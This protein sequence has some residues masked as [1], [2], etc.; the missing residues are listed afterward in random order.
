MHDVDIL[1]S[2]VARLE[3][4]NRLM[5]HLVAA[6]CVVAVALGTMAQAVPVGEM[7]ATAFVLVDDGGQVIGRLG[8]HGGSPTLELRDGRGA[9]VRLRANEARGTIEYRDGDGRLVDVTRAHYGVVR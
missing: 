5:R 8:T 9:F 6:V 1:A 3:R 4:Q 7:R 2:R